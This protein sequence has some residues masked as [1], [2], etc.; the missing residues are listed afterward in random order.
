[1]GRMASELSNPCRG[2]VFPIRYPGLARH[3]RQPGAWKSN[4]TAVADGQ[5]GGLVIQTLCDCRSTNRWAIGHLMGIGS[6]LSVSS[7]PRV[8]IARRE[9][10]VG[11]GRLA[12]CRGRR[13]PFW[14]HHRSGSGPAGH[15]PAGSDLRGSC[16]P[17]SIF[18][19]AGESLPDDPTR[20]RG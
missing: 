6:C 13:R 19:R 20:T 15:R 7:A 17:T 3:T 8:A 2:P 4:R 11:P 14:C 10:C 16:R 5:T 12:F 9:R 1:M 18:I